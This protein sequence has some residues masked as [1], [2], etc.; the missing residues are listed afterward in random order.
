MARLRLSLTLPGAVSLGAY[1]GGALAALLLACQELGEQA[2]VI[3]S[4]ASASAG[5]ITGL[6]SARALL[7]GTDP[8]RLLARAWVELVSLRAMQAH[9]TEAPLSGEALSVIATDLLGPGGVPD[10]PDDRRQ[11]EPVRLS[12]ALGNLA[13]LNYALPVVDRATPM[14]ASTFLDW[15]NVTLTDDL[16][17]GRYLELAQAAIAS[18]ADAIGFPPKQLDRSADR[19]QYDQAGLAGF[20]ADG[21]F[22]YT[23][24]GTIDNE[25]LGRTIDLAQSV[26]SDDDRV[27]LL[28]HPDPVATTDTPSPTWTGN[29]PQPSWLHAGT[30]AFAIG[31]TQTIFE[32]LKRLEKTNSYLE[33]TKAI[34]AA[35]QAGVTEAIE[36]LGLSAGQADTLRASLQDAAAAE[37]SKIRQQQDRAREIA[38][39]SPRGHRAV[40]GGYAETLQAL[41]AAATGL[42]GKR[43]AS[44][45]VVSPAIDPAVTEP[46]SEQLAGAFLFH[47]GGF[48]DIRYR[49][50]DF[51]LGYRNMQYWLEHDLA[52]YLEGTD[53]TGALASVADGYRRLGWDD[54][55]CGGAQLGSLGTGEKVEL[56]EVA[57]HVL[58]VIR[59]DIT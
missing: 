43:P 50:S 7:R 5:S 6:L 31:R 39:R 2:V 37:L 1:E 44:V 15:Y 55:R 14:Q 13:G 23:D 57:L 30:R 58:N 3:D 49:Q 24:G 40:S 27:F 32:D 53:M 38:R 56:G 42:E 21:K 36:A 22:W 20:P 8:I 54:I 46:A 45:D 35:V 19:A 12:M 48:I 29:S 11:R 16:D 18:G 47:F 26:G 51:A 28:I 34:P 59:H 41:V 52:R 17:A 33:W 25:P 10:G 4:M 9:S